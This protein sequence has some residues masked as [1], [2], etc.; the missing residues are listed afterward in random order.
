MF[1]GPE[2]LPLDLTDKNMRIHIE[3]MHYQIEAIDDFDK[4]IQFQYRKNI[5]LTYYNYDDVDGNWGTNE[6]R[7]VATTD[8]EN[9][10]TGFQDLLLQ[11]TALFEYETVI[12]DWGKPFMILCCQR[13]GDIFSLKAQITE[14]HVE[15]WLTV[16]LSQLSFEQLNEYAQIFI[17][18]AKDYPVLSEEELAIAKEV[19]W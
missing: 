16:E 3:L 9:I 18:W 2:T 12:D 8:L 13:N 10:A 11:K 15:E 4:D 5:V 1:F 17:R 14:S 7:Y 6:G 19:P